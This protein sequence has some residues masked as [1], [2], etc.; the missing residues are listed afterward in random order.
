MDATAR[1]QFTE[2]QISEVVLDCAY[3]VH[4]R[5]G[6]GLLESTYR[7]CLAHELIKAGLRVRQEVSLPVEYDG[8]KLDAGY[9]IDLLVE[10]RVILELKCVDKLAAVHTAQVL[11]YLRLS[12]MRL[13]IILNFYSAHLRDG[14]KRVVN[15][16]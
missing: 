4:T 10:E 13:G 9:R 5:L 12:K 16:L 7:V 3:R 2:D 8:I 11:A 15:K 1:R 14:I 6:P